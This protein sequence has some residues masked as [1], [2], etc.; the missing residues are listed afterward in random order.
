VGRGGS[1]WRRAVASRRSVSVGR[2]SGAGDVHRAALHG[3]L[4]W[5]SIEL[6]ERDETG[7]DATRRDGTGQDGTGRDGR[8][9]WCP[10]PT[11]VTSSPTRTRASAAGPGRTE[12]SEPGWTATDPSYSDQV[13]ET[14]TGRGEIERTGPGRVGPG[15]TATNQ[16]QDDIASTL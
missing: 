2:P 10:V 15:R 5:L 9:M 11:T 1:S 13:R 3:L 7:R 16:Q 12:T 6:D 14:E 4:A 8:D